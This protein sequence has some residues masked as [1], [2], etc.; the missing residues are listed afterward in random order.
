M[1]YCPSLQRT[2]HSGVRQNV[3][4][5]IPAAVAPVTCQPPDFCPLLHEKNALPSVSTAG[6][7]VSYLV[8]TSQADSA[9]IKIHLWYDAGSFFQHTISTKL[10]IQIDLNKIRDISVYVVTKRQRYA[11]WHSSRLPKCLEAKAQ[12]TLLMMPQHHW[13]ISPAWAIFFMSEVHKIN[14]RMPKCFLRDTWPQHCCSSQMLGQFWI[15]T[16]CPLIPFHYCEIDAYGREQTGVYW[17]PFSAVCLAENRY[18]TAYLGTPWRR[19]SCI[20]M[21][22]ADTVM[23]YHLTS[24]CFLRQSLSFV[25]SVAHL[26]VLDVWI[27]SVYL[28]VLI[29]NH[30]WFLPRFCKSLI[31]EHLFWAGHIAYCGRCR[32]CIGNIN[33]YS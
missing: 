21:R 16:F 3:P 8:R 11:F 26:L 1:S 18:W 23:R 29:H 2:N 4:Y 10:L 31:F 30:L 28:A 9:W 25:P 5:P 19:G 24:W 27:L 15:N 12:D 33:L 17:A 32:D 6:R 14:Y 13:R 7:L 20:V 22:C